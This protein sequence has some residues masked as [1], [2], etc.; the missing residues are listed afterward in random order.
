MRIQAVGTICIAY[1]LFSLN[2]GFKHMFN[3]FYQ[4]TNKIK[5]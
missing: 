4:F 2:F 5:K 3:Y 1:I